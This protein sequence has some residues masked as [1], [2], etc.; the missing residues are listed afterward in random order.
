MKTIEERA[1]RAY[2]VENNPYEKIKRTG[3]IC[4]AKEQK[5]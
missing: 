2:P 1:K 3:Y 4:G 5:Q